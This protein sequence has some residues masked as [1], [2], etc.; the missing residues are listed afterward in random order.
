MTDR[1]AWDAEVPLSASDDADKGT[2]IVGFITRIEFVVVVVA[3]PVVAALYFL[4]STR[5]AIPGRSL[6][7]SPRVFPEIIGAGLLV[8]SLIVAVGHAR[9]VLRGMHEPVAA[10]TD[11][12]E[13]FG[14]GEV[15]SWRDLL[16]GLA[17]CL[18]A[19]LNFERFG[20]Y[21]SATVLMVCTSLFLEP[22]RWKRNIVV[23]I[24][25]I[26]VMG[27]LFT[28]LGITLPRGVLG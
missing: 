7:V 19:L 11:E 4:E 8:S 1:M 17:F 2:R 10:T 14:E 25:V 15:D 9:A 12:D 22:H 27:R 28:A 18:V 20:Y 3:I 5:L 21:I 6:E 23:G 16:A 13:E 26:V 24:I